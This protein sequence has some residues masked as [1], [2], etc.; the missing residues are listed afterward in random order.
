MKINKCL[1]D[2][3]D[4]GHP[5]APQNLYDMFCVEESPRKYV[6]DEVTIHYRSPVRHE[7]KEALSEEE[8]ARRQAEAMRRIYQEERRRK[9]LQ[10]RIYNSWSNLKTSHLYLLLLARNKWI[11]YQMV[12][13]YIF[14]KLGLFYKLK[15]F[16]KF[17]NGF[18]ILNFGKIF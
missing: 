16:K 1:R 2:I 7:I 15:I 17:K 18:W 13:R 8:L 3:W 10:V 14:F 9:Y 6:E 12:N 11:L 5:S 4:V